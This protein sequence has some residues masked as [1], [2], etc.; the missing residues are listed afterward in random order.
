MK[1]INLRLSHTRKHSFL[2]PSLWLSCFCL[3]ICLL[4]NPVVAH[5]PRPLKIDITHIN[6]DGHVVVKWKTP[7]ALPY[8]SRPFVELVAPC[9]PRSEVLESRQTNAYFAR[10]DYLCPQTEN[11]AI[12]LRIIYPYGNPSLASFIKYQASDRL[13]TPPIT[14]ML[15]PDRLIWEV[16]HEISETKNRAAPIYLQLGFTHILEGWDHLLFLLC[17]IILSATPKRLLLGITGFTVSHSISLAAASLGLVSVP[18]LL[19]EA[20]IALSIVFLAAEILRQDKNTLAWRY[21]VITAFFFGLLHG[22]GFANVLYHLGLPEGNMIGAL[23]FFNLGVEFGQIVFVLS[24]LILAYLLRL[25]ARQF[26]TAHQR[27]HLNKYTQKTVI[28]SAGLLAG[29]WSVERF[30]A[31]FA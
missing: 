13:A 29:Y 28:I 31:L 21:P 16:P 30:I 17:L 10:Q 23:L 18:I 6:S 15:A 8:K 2:N 11:A 4:T 3:S 27:D 7:A 20:L 26:V 24:L 1:Q 9:Q 25:P 22:F 14:H 19:V 5:D 12:K